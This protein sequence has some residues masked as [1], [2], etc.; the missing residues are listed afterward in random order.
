MSELLTGT[1]IHPLILSALGRS[2]HGSKVLISDGNFPHE[3]ASSNAATIVYL[4]VAPGLLSVGQILPVLRGAIPIESA[5]VMAGPAGA[6]D[7]E[8]FER[9]ERELS[10]RLQRLDRFE[11]YEAA[12][13]RDVSLVIASGDTAHYANLLLTIGTNDPH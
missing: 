6:P 8:P 12:R 4:N 9:Y 1:L 3:T 13:S 10:L 7:P 2:G 5:T 11:F